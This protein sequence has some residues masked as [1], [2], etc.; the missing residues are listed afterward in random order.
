MT[1]CYWCIL[2]FQL[3]ES[4]LLAFWNVVEEGRVVSVGEF[5]QLYRR[6]ANSN[7]KFLSQNMIRRVFTVQHNCQIWYEDSK[8][9]DAAIQHIAYVN[10]QLWHP[11]GRYVTKER[12]VI[13]LFHTCVQLQHQAF[14]VKVTSLDKETEPADAV[15]SF[16]LKRYLT[17]YFALVDFFLFSLLTLLTGC[18]ISVRSKLTENFLSGIKPHDCHRC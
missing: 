2:I 3:L 14:Q 7:M 11:V 4:W 18:H 15:T 16:L 17:S 5:K 1:C 9:V 13:V 8:N 10:W 6:V 12:T